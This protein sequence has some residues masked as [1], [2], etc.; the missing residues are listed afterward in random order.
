MSLKDLTVLVTRPAPK[1]HELCNEIQK[2]GGTPVL[3]PA[4]DIKPLPI[5]PE[6]DLNKYRKLVFLSQNAVL[7]SKLLLQSLNKEVEV[8][9]IGSGTKAAL[10]ELAVN[11]DFTP[12]EDFTSQGLLALGALK[13]IENQKIAIIKGEGG[14]DI[15]QDGL[16]SKG[17][18]CEAIAVYRR[19]IP[20]IKDSKAIN[21]LLKNKID[22][23]ICTSGEILQNLIFMTSPINLQEIPLLV[24]SDRILSDAKKLGFKRVFLTNNA[25]HSAIISYLVELKDQ[26]CQTKRIKK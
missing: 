8:F 15:L 1:G 16:S 6:V 19:V 5:S 21:M 4:I 7:H 11:V 20:T 18:I 23:I 3:F 17:A 24:I 14:L 22:I 26:L 25:S 12:K 2:L 9:A 10:E 13:H